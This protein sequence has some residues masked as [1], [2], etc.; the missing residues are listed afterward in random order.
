MIFQATTALQYSKRR[1]EIAVDNLK[2]RH[3]DATIDFAHGKEKGWEI[4]ASTAYAGAKF[5]LSALIIG[6]VAQLSPDV[7]KF[8]LGS[9]L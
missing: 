7:P 8:V 9:A 1:A 4:G 2:T 6:G 5:N 3:I